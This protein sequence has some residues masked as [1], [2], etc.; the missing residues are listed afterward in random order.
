MASVSLSLTVDQATV[1]NPDNVVTG[2]NAPGTGD[3]E[4]RVN[5]AKFTQIEQIWLALEQ[6]DD[7][8]N[9]SGKG[10]LAFGVL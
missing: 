2:T 6:F 10:P 5:M 4:L 9:D 3:I 8:L 7:Y 1:R